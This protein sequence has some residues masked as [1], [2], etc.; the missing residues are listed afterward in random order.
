[1]MYF[2]FFES[3]SLYYSNSK[4]A[5]DHLQNKGTWLGSSKTL[6]TKQAVSEF[7][8]PRLRAGCLNCRCVTLRE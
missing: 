8:N 5:V 7:A 6:L 3:Y 2:R 4:A 1:M